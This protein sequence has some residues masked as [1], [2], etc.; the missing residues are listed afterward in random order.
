M[1]KRITAM[2]MAAA[3]ALALIGCGSEPV[4]E[5]AAQQ[6]E[7]DVQTAEKNEEQEKAGQETAGTA[8]IDADSIKIGVL[9]STTGDFSISETPMRNVAEMA[10][11][12]I[13]EAGGIAGVPIEAVFMDYGS[14]PSMA[15]EKAEELILNDKVAAI[16]GTNSSSTRLAVEPIVE[17]Y[18]SLLVYNTFY[19]GETP[20]DN[21]LYTGT[22]PSQQVD[23]F[24]PYIIENLGTKIFFVGSD[25]EFP[26]NTISYA[27]NLV[28]S[29]GGEIVGEEYAPSGETD[30]SSIVN[31]IKEAE[32]DVIFSAV[33]G[34]SSVYF[35]SD[36]S[37][38][39][40]N[41]EDTPICSVACHEGT[42]KGIGE[43]AVGSYSCFSYFNTID[44]QANKAFVQKYADIYGTDTTVN[45]SAE[46]TYHGIYMLA[47]AIEK[48][49]SLNSQDIIA[50]AAGIKVDTPS[51]TI[52]MDENNH[53][54]YLNI[55]IGKVN[56]NLTFDIIS[57]TDELIAPVVD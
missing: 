31:K 43:A 15:A 23:G 27:K 51:G 2:M 47:E 37:Q 18:D 1:K 39:G 7:S 53:H 42:V 20:S 16:V 28:E 19:E 32:P 41:Q 30:F 14:E 3:M 6:T 48:A 56:E 21:L 11:N 45:N 36:C 9:L 50:A 34:N 46:A 17:Q 49:G 55:Y 26:R 5:A 52:K 40:L 33:A 8:G 22:V 57:S 24:I 29:L 12:E 54:A 35:Y 13:N 25:Y 4:Q 10:I 44:T 38:Y